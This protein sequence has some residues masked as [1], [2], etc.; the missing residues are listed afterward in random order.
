MGFLIDYKYYKFIA[1]IPGWILGDIIGSISAFLLV[2]ELVD[3]K[4]VDLFELSLLF[5]DS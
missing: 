3:N 4:E 5:F 2:R 1:I